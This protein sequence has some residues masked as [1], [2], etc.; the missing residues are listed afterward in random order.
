M[1]NFAPVI[2]KRLVAQNE[3]VGWMRGLV[4][5]LQN[6][7]HP[8]E[9][10]TDLKKKERNSLLFYLSLL[11][12]RWQD[13][14]YMSHNNSCNTDTQH[15]GDFVDESP[16]QICITALQISVFTTGG[17]R[18]GCRCRCLMCRLVVLMTARGRCF[19]PDRQYRLH[20]AGQI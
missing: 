7:V 9:S 15:L 5:G 17:I 16:L 4:N 10:G 6:R 14:L 20:C 18:T 1:L 13:M 3:M 2:R 12:V 19:V 8:F 11:I